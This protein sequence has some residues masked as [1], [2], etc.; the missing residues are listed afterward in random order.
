MKTERLLEE[1]T[2][3]AQRLGYEVRTEK[4]NFRGG[5]C[6]VGGARLIVLNTRYLPEQRLAV[7][8]ECLRAEA[9]GIYL[10]P[11]VRDAL[12]TLWAEQDAAAQSDAQEAASPTT[13]AEEIAEA[14]AD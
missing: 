6:A 9:E 12:E 1:L 5:R 4:G 3:A 8:A 10:K 13:P 11:A 7:L 2:D 14:H